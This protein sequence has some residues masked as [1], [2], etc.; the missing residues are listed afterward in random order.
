MLR[1]WYPVCFFIL[2]EKYIEKAG[3]PMEM[4]LFG[5]Y[6]SFSTAYS[7]LSFYSPRNENLIFEKEKTIEIYCQVLNRS[8]KLTWSLSRNMVDIP[9]LC[10]SGEPL[11]ANRFKVSIPSESLR[12]GFYDLSV[13]ADCGGGT[14]GGLC[15][16]GWKPE[17]MDICDTRPGDFSTFWKKGLEKLAEVPLEARESFYADYSG[18]QIDDYNYARA[19]LP[20]DYDPCGHQTEKVEASKISFAGLGGIRIYGWLAKPKGKGP[21]KV[22]LVLPGAGFAA[23]PIPLEHAR[24]G[25]LALDIQV[26]GQKV[27]Q[28]EYKSL[29]GYGADA[30]YDP[31]DRYYYHNVYLNCVQAVHYLL[32]RE[33]ADASRLAVVGGSQGGRLTT[34]VAALDKRVRAAVP[35]ITHFANLPYLDFAR[36]ANDAGS[37]GVGM[38]AARGKSVR[39]RCLAYYD[40]MNFAPDVVCPVLMNVG[41]IDRVSPPSGV[42][43]VYNRLRSEKKAIIPLPGLA[44]DWSAEFDRRAWRWLEKIWSEGKE[45]MPAAL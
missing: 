27:D 12:P 17:E 31:A 7:G 9:F 42:F 32:S 13:T 35:A 37:D 44:H 28:Q 23:R 26:H 24:H 36:A 18:A 39:S 21:F 15:A 38:D 4:N 2:Y 29:P 14:V 11:P 3:H 45:H 10:G 8:V 16:F 34:V 33:D 41:L 6:S 40:V 5:K 20:P 30:I 19:C 22:M 25:Y 1:E 43:A